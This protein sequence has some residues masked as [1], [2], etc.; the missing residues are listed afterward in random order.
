MP[1]V[2]ITGAHGFLGRYSSFTFKKN[3]WRVIGIGH[4]H[5][6][7]ETPANYGIDKW[8]E[9]DINF[10]TLAEINEKLDCVVHCAGGSSVGYSV[11]YPLQDFNKTVTTSIN[12]LEYIRIHQPQAKFIYPS[13]AAVYGKKNNTAICETDTLSPISPY[14]FHK[15]VVEELCASYS[16]NFSLSIRIIRFFS[17]YG[18]GLKKQLLWD[19]CNRLSSA[20]GDLLF[21]GTGLETRDWV[22]VKDAANLIFK[23]ASIAAPNII[24]LNGGTGKTRT[25]QQILNRLSTLF[26]NNTDIVFNNRSREGDPKHYQADISNTEKYN[27]NPKNNVEDGLK[28]Y[29]QWFKRQKQED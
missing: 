7:F 22:H 24:I 10:Y 3:N 21:F 16:I 8:I 14:G 1:T 6:G 13:S 12:L 4:G 20:K 17:I 25:T 29:V 11:Q 28:E 27:W 15:K 18:P 2:L 5:W 26:K 23:L 19:A 9:A